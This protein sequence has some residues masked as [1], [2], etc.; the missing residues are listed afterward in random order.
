M[1]FIALNEITSVKQNTCIIAHYTLNTKNNDIF[2]LSKTCFLCYN[3]LMH[4]IFEAINTIS[5]I[6][7][8]VGIFIILVGAAKGFYRFIRN[9][10]GLREI[11][12]ELGSHTILGLD[13]LVGKDI[14]D[15]LLLGTESES[16]VY[17]HLIGLF[18]VVIIRIILTYFTGKEL[19]EI[20]AI[21]AKGKLYKTQNKK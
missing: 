12:L 6:V 11:R 13:F 9:N 16:E 15:T 18:S 17:T 21:V 10:T 1:A 20:E 5:F 2:L 14:I 7:G 8:L 19:R 4:Y 3:I